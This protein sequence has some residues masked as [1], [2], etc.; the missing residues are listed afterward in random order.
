MSVCARGLR[1]PGI[2]LD[3]FPR[4]LVHPLQNVVRLPVNGSRQATMS[5]WSRWVIVSEV[6]WKS[7]DAKRVVALSITSP[8]CHQIPAVLAKHRPPWLER[9]VEPSRAYDGVKFTACPILH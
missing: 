1:R 3:A 2:L 9:D 8:F 6:V 4:Y 7:A 5:D